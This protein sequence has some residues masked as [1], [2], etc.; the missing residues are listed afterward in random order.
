MKK[1]LLII[2]LIFSSFNAFAQTNENPF[3]QNRFNPDISLIADMAFISSD[4]KDESRE[5][6]E[7]PEFMH[8][9][10]HSHMNK[11]RGVHLNYLELSFAAPIDPYFDFFGVMT[12]APGHGLELEEVYADTKFLPY[13]FGARLGLFK[14]AI[15]RHNEKHAHNWDF[16]DS[17]L[18]YDALLGSE[19]ISDVGLRLTYTF[20]LDF[21]LMLGA[22]VF[23][24]SSDEAVSFNAD[25]YTFLDKEIEPKS[26]PALFTGFL[27]TS[28]DFGDHI[29]L[30]GSSILYGPSNLIHSH[31][32][33]GEEAERPDHSIE[34]DG[35]VVYGF[36]L[37]YKYIID[38]YRYVSFEGE[39][40]SRIIDGT[41]YKLNDNG[42]PDNESDDKADVI[43]LHKINSGLYGQILFK[44]DKRWRTG[45]RADYLL[46]P[47]IELD[48]KSVDLDID[49]LYKLSY[50]IEYYFSEF[51][52][53]RAQYNYD[54]SR[55]FEESMKPIQEFIFSFNFAVGAHGA[56]AF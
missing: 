17:P 23:Q 22:E 21:M 1:L 18:I 29:F 35:T 13:G 11:E 28:F 43:A 45:L 5:H 39:Y 24:G 55:Y 20:P 34:A 41:L 52:R 38:A 10:P 31:H 27:K 33:E 19:G 36:D 46:K 56:H 4:I 50:M 14:S 12:Y 47:S 37:T 16:Y 7:I 51:A 6:L 26:K 2:I 25:G 48:S 44:F 53:F 54:H 32:H 30:L 42:T 15:G 9:P 49:Q 40:L 8:H 3:I